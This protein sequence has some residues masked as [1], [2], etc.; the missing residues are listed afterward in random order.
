MT[1]WNAVVELPTAALAASVAVAGC[2]AVERVAV[3]TGS[4][5]LDFMCVTFP[6]SVHW[7]WNHFWQ[8]SLSKLFSLQ[9]FAHTASLLDLSL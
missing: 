8:A 3:S 9:N 1:V 4:S 6:K 7:L 2:F 5:W